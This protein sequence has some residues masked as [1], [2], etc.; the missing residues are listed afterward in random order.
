VGEVNYIDSSGLGELVKTHTTIRNKGGEL[1]LTNL[2]KKVHDLLHLTRLS[3]V[4]DIETD[5]ATALDS[6]GMRA[7]SQAVA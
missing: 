6:F 5:E 1:K 7:T 3:A 4:F 2:N